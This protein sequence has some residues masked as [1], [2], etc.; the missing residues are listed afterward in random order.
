MFGHVVRAV[1]AI[2]SRVTLYPRRSLLLVSIH[3]THPSSVFLLPVAPTSS[4]LAFLGPCNRVDELPAIVYNG[5]PTVRETRYD[6]QRRLM[7]LRCLPDSASKFSAS[8]LLFLPFP[9]CPLPP[10]Y[11]LTS[12]TTPGMIGIILRQAFIFY[13]IAGNYFIYVA[14]YFK[15]ERFRDSNLYLRFAGSN[16]TVGTNKM[17]DAGNGCAASN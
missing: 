15:G 11:P 12:F 16:V 6:V 3:S 2:H 9:L 17:K 8:N 13:K 4:H 14:C 1:P 7:R 10:F 5:I